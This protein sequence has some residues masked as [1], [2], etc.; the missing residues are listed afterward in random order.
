MANTPPSSNDG[1]VKADECGCKVEGGATPCSCII[2]L[3]NK[4][5]NSSVSGSC[6]DIDVTVGCC[7]DRGGITTRGG[8]AIEGGAAIG[9]GA[10][11]GDGTA[12]E[13]GATSAGRARLLSMESRQ[14]DTFLTGGS[15]STV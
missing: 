5:E 13:G 11:S 9:G 1:T 8:A 10:I 15:C 2:L 7:C 12:I 4:K 6:E 14:N 3:V